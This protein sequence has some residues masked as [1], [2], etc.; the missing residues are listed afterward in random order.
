MYAVLI[1]TQ[2][3][4]DIYAMMSSSWK[5]RAGVLLNF[6]NA[7]LDKMIEKQIS[8]EMHSVLQNI[9]PAADPK[10]SAVSSENVQQL[11]QIMDKPAI[12]YKIHLNHQDHHN[13]FSSSSS[14][15]LINITDEHEEEESF[16]KPI[17]EEEKTTTTKR[18]TKS[19]SSFFERNCKGSHL[20]N[21][22]EEH[23]NYRSSVGDKNTKQLVVLKTCF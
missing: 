11:P 18:D 19:T 3:C 22:Q 14:S 10:I 1:F 5:A 12:K 17:A 6:S 9:Q 4:L 20:L 23:Y 16:L 8:I 2:S 21:Q 15:S 7:C 13:P